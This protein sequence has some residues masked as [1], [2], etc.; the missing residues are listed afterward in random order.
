MALIKDYLEKTEEHRKT[1]GEKS[2]VLMQVGQFFEIYGL[3]EART[4]RIFGSA[5]QEVSKDCDLSISE[6]KVCVGKNG[7]VMS[8]F[9]EFGLDKFL[10]RMRDHGYTIAVYVQDAQ[11]KNT[12]RSLL[13]VYSPGTYFA[14]ESTS[15][16]N[17]IVS[18]WI[19]KITSRVLTKKNGGKPCVYI[20][21]STIDIFTG[22]SYIFQCSEQYSH[23]PTTFDEIERFISIYRPNEV[24]FIYRN[25]TEQAI[26]DIINF[27]GVRCDSIRKINVD[28][29][30]NILCKNAKNSE[31]QSY[32]KELL[33]RFYKVAD[34]DSF[35]EQYYQYPMATNSFCFLL[36]YIYSHNQSLVNKIAQPVFENCSNRLVLANHSLQQLNINPTG[37][38]GVTNKRLSSVSSFLNRCITPMGKR[39]F[40]YDLMHPVTSP[41]VLQ[42]EYDITEYF[43]TNFEKF[44]YVQGFL[45]EIKD[46]EKLNRKIVLRKI[47]PQSLYLFYRNL[48]SIKKIYRKLKQDKTFTTYCANFVDDKVDQTCDEFMQLFDKSIDIDLCKDIDTLMF[49][50]NFMKRGVFPE[51]D[52]EV[53]KHKE[54]HDILEAIREYLDGLVQKNEKKT[55]KKKKTDLVKIYETEKMGFSL[56]TTKRRS[57]FLIK[58]LDKEKEDGEIAEIEYTSSYTNETAMFD[59][60]IS[61]ITCY[62]TSSSN[63]TIANA[64]IRQVCSDIITS[65]N[66]MKDQLTLIYG[67]FIGDLEQYQT[68]FDNI[69]QYVTLIDMVYTKAVIAKK[70]NYCKPVIGVKTGE[71][72]TGKKTTGKKTK[73][74]KKKKQERTQERIQERTKSFVEFKGLRHCL[75][76]HLQTNE[77][78]VSN[79][80]SLGKDVNGILLYGTNAVGKTSFIKSLGIAVIMAQAG[81]YVPCSEFTYY[82]YTAIF[83]RILGND[84]IF[85]GLSTF[86]VEMTELRTILRMNNEQSLILGD[87]LCSGTESDSAISIFVTGLMELHKKNSSFIFATHFHEIVNFEEIL[88]ME[89]L[90]MMHMTVKYDKEND[91]LMYDRK[92][93]EGPGESMYGLEVCKSL[94][95]PNNFLEMAYSIRNKYNKKSRGILSQGQS[96]YNS[97]KLKGGICELCMME[98]ASDIHHLQYQNEANSEGIIIKNEISFHKNHKANLASVC[99]GCHDK[100]HQN[101][102]KIRRVKTSDGYVFQEI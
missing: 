42:R 78:Y 48:E 81:L 67:K 77:I 19:E 61:N 14:A 52:K 68:Q 69:I 27:S 89:R 62:T 46:I 17:H 39:R 91:I 73:T 22:K 56:V 86:A 12:T 35:F 45:S 60:D 9:P 85:K 51:L 34:I 28:S 8:G 43:I 66:K 36:D 100:I 6:K 5:I 32:Q 83:T 57:L 63:Q 55:A 44:D 10:K 3:K 95:L 41:E 58:E 72:T 92:L 64:D 47:T 88:S 50:T 21:L 15:I 102:T 75:I 40:N 59:F 80:L 54:S 38:A 26:N 11:T 4:K 13:G 25:F 71:Q 82:P 74:N 31:R 53:Q 93:K 33:N 23:T 87:E 7:V 101:D 30:E 37:E 29:D 49:D 98:P 70:F 97:D 99:K 76:E 90:R 65:K 96:R 84:N 79:D 24:L 1:Y 16:T 94:N 2:V 18:V 20:G